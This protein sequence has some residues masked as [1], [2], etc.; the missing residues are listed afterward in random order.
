MP[1]YTRKSPRIPKYDYNNNNFYFITLCTH[2]KKCIFWQG[3]KMNQLGIIAKKHI[4]NIGSHHNGVVVDKYVVM[5]NHIHMIVALHE[6]DLSVNYLVALFKTGV[7]KQIRKH[8][9]KMQIWQR[10]FHD[11]IIRNQADYV[12]IW[13]YIDTNPQRWNEDCFYQDFRAD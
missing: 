5:P 1:F 8:Y 2:E 12:R 11:H 9:P 3:Q 7:T 10:S 6:S 13:S 4:E